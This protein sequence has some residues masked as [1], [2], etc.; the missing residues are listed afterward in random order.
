M[1]KVFLSLALCLGIMTPVLNAHEF[2]EDMP[3]RESFVK[4]VI[5]DKNYP[6]LVKGVKAAAAVGVAA[7]CVYE[8]FHR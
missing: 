6:S 4:Y 1:K 8:I 3:P 2:E 5:S 7:F